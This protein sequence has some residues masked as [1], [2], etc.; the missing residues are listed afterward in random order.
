MSTSTHQLR[1]HV[2]RGR[3]SLCRMAA[4]ADVPAWAVG[5]LVSVTRTDSELSIIWR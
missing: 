1:L 3:Y 4:T 5:E 2:L